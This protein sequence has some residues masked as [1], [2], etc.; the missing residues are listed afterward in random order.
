MQM[1]LGMLRLLLGTHLI[2]A[3][4]VSTHCAYAQFNVQ[5]IPTLSL[6]TS[7]YF[8]DLEILLQQIFIMY[9]NGDLLIECWFTKS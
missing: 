9:G 6:L 7:E 1:G 4:V 3:L 5:N 8:R 2:W